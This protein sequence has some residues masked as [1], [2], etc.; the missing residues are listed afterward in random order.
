M[1]VGLDIMLRVMDT[2]CRAIMLDVMDTA[3]KGGVL[4]W[5]GELLKLQSTTSS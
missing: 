2:A 3:C 1:L 4:C 5:S